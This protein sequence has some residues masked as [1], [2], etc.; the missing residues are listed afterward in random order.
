VKRHVNGYV[1]NRV[2]KLNV[3]FL[4][5]AGAGNQHETTLDVP[6]IRVDDDVD[7]DYLKGTL[8]LSRTQEGILVQGLLYAGIEAECMR[9]LDPVQSAMP[10]EFEELY[11]Y[12]SLPDSEFSIVED[13]I[14]DLAPLL[15]AEVI[16]AEEHG[17][18]CSPD[19]QGLCPECGENLNRSRCS[20]N[21]L[22][23]D[24]RLEKLR[25]LR[26]QMGQS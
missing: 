6:P 1:G 18:L 13:G 19:C 14:L 22:K 4:L 12:P 11:A 21:D 2:L 26:D 17:A 23:I 15:R 5:N 10:I 25:A 8:R 3:G 20:C 7:L 9:C 16:I 24:P